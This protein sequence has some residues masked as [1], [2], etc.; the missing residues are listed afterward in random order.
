MK[1]ISAIIFSILLALLFP[2]T[3]IAT[4]NLW[5]YKERHEYYEKSQMEQKQRDLERRIEDLEWRSKWGDSVSARLTEK[6]IQAS[7]EA[8]KKSSTVWSSIPKLTDI[9]PKISIAGKPM[10]KYFLSSAR[11]HQAAIEFI[12]SN[13]EIRTVYPLKEGI[14]SIDWMVTIPQRWTL[15][16][17]VDLQQYLNKQ[18]YRDFKGRELSS[19]GEYGAYTLSAHMAYF[20]SR[21]ECD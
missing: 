13:S 2:T 7:R 4:V 9:K 3:A 20:Y 18:G 14:G 17:I 10:Y 1:N 5:D 21:Y 15:P 11:P 8:I 19:D 6:D 12:N 16:Q